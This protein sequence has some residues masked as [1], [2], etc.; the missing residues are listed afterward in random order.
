MQ[1]FLKALALASVIFAPFANA[2]VASLGDKAV[3]LSQ[4]KGEVVD[5]RALCPAGVTCIANGTVISLKFTLAGCFDTLGPVSYDVDASEEGKLKVYVSAL[6][7]HDKR[8][9]AAFC[10]VAP[11]A[12]ATITLISKYGTPDV[13]FLAAGASK[14]RQLPIEEPSEDDVTT[15]ISCRENV[16]HGAEVNFLADANG[17]ILRAV[18]TE[19]SIVDTEVVS[20]MNVCRRHEIAEHGADTYNKT[21]T[22]KD[23]SWVDGYDVE[24]FEGGYSGIPY[25]KILKGPANPQLV[26]KLYCR[27]R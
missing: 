16:D 10:Y 1:N 8:S 25:V 4:L 15:A 5:V 17:E 23:T 14:S 26:K 18:Y 20:S 27:Y 13:R 9:A 2:E 21:V 19:T 24:L 22:C 3:G 12:H 11:T 6:N 7:I